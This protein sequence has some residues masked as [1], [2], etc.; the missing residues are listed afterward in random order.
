MDGECHSILIPPPTS[1]QPASHIRG[2]IIVSSVLRLRAWEREESY[3]SS[4]PPV[5]RDEVLS[6]APNSWV[7]MSVAV[8]HY[9]AVQC[10]LPDEADQVEWGRQ[11]ADCV[12]K[13]Y[14]ITILREIRVTGLISPE[15]AL[16]HLRPAWRRVFQG[17]SIHA[18]KRG[19]TRAVLTV[20]GLELLE[21][22]L[23]RR[24]MQG[25]LEKTF[26]ITK[27]QPKV[28]SKERGPSSAEFTFR[29]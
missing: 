17:S 16:R 10:A 24:S 21:L 1:T 23:F 9:E 7:P 12:H 8:P 13:A 25:L 14:V 3:L 20:E 4:V 18:E 5:L 6:T 26:A 11:G 2:T 15:L 19:L 28:T 22:P 29:W 27:Q